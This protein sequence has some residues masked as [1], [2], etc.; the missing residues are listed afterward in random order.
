MQ[1]KSF[2]IKKHIFRLVSFDYCGGVVKSGESFLLKSGSEKAGNT[3]VIPS[4]VNISNKTSTVIFQSLKASCVLC[5]T[6]ILLGS[7]ASLNHNKK[8]HFNLAIAH[9]TKQL[10]TRISKNWESLELSIKRSDEEHSHYGPIIDT[11]QTDF[12]QATREHYEFQHIS[13]ELQTFIKK[14]KVPNTSYKPFNYLFA[15]EIFQR[16]ILDSLVRQS[17]QFNSQTPGTLDIIKM[18][19]GDD[20]TQLTC[21][22]YFPIHWHRHNKQII[23]HGDTL[24]QMNFPIKYPNEIDSLELFL[25]KNKS[26]VIYEP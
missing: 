20:S 14:N 1:Y 21:E 25:S 6:L 12:R 26:I 8:Q 23:I 4:F 24:G 5:V 19:Q 17:H 16:S 13:V 3:F 11:L 7:Q 9:E 22:I 10:E 15:I 2:Q 18:N